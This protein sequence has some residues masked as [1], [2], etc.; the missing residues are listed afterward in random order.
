MEETGH[1]FVY[2]PS[3]EFIGNFEELYQHTSDP[4]KQS[5]NE[6]FSK[7][8]IKYHTKSIVDYFEIVSLLEVGC[9]LG[10]NLKF[11]SKNR[12]LRLTGID[13][14]ETAVDYCKRSVSSA[15]I[16][17][18][19]AIHIDNIPYHEAI[20]F[21]EI[22][23]YLLENKKLETIFL[24]MKTNFSNALFIHNL[25]FYKENQSYGREYFTNLDEFISFCPFSLL[26]RFETSQPSSNYILT[27]S[28]FR[29]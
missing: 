15:D 29:I 12:K 9:G 27:S 19:D 17:Q 5:K 4:W 14:S 16:Y 13:V 10:F 23:W 24:K 22:S 7:L 25:V 3:G 28:L 18:M 20:L 11:L 2:G 26:S 21:S 1:N 6:Y 8:A